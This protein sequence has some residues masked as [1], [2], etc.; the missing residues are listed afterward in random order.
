MVTPPTCHLKSMTLRVTDIWG[1]TPCWGGVG[2]VGSSA[3]RSP[4]PLLKKSTLERLS[5]A[6][7]AG[8]KTAYREGKQEKSSEF[9][10]K[11]DGERKGVGGWRCREGM[12]G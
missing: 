7:D 8:G 6:T 1:A 9:L 3:E 2:A 11:K 4:V 12:R 5:S 10:I